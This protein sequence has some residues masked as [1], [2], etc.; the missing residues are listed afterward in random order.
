MLFRSLTTGVWVGAEERSV[1]FRSTRLGQGSHTALP[2]W[3]YYMRK[4]YNDPSLHISQG[5]FPK[6]NVPNADL[7]FNCWGNDSS[8]DEDDFDVEFIDEF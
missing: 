1:R 8:D 2:I 4:V 5:D 3:A 6:P 7:D